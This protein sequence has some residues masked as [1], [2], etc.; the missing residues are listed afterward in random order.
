MCHSL[1]VRVAAEEE[2]CP[3]WTLSV[4]D[5]WFLYDAKDRKHINADIMQKA[6]EDIRNELGFKGGCCGE[7]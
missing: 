6:W 1:Q 4:Q 7:I 5:E 3:V 2:M